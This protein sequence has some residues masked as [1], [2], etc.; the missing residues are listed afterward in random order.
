MPVIRR[1]SSETRFFTH[2]ANFLGEAKQ[3]AALLAEL[4]TVPWRRENEALL[5][6]MHETS[7]TSC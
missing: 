5:A 6:L 7:Q 3:V 4:Q 2:L 1:E